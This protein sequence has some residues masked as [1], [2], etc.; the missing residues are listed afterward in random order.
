MSKKRANPEVRK[1]EPRGRNQE[2]IEENSALDMIS[3]APHS[4]TLKPDEYQTVRIL[5][6]NGS[7]VADGE[8]RS[9]LQIKMTENDLDLETNKPA[10]DATSIVPKAKITTVIPVI[11]RKGQRPFECASR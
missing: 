4:I 6:K 3:I 2:S 9:H 10:I 5:V 1:R 8:Y 7:D 11:I